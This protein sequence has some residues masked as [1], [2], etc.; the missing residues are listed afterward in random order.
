MQI[1]S[2]TRIC[3]ACVAPAKNNLICK[4]IVKRE[5]HA[6]RGALFQCGSSACVSVSTTSVPIL[7]SGEAHVP[8]CTNDCLYHRLSI[9]RPTKRE[10]EKS[11]SDGHC[12]YKT[13]MDEHLVALPII[14]EIVPHSDPLIFD[15]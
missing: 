10:R 8:Y 9:N 12:Q 4:Y 11:P 2:R 13:E 5:T 1:C 15:N 14:F 7:E 3:P 6:G